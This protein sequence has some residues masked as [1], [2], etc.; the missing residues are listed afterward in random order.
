MSFDER[1]KLI[2]SR[3][4]EVF[5]SKGLEGATTRELAKAA[6]VSEGLL[7]KHFPNKEAIYMAMLDSI[8]A[9]FPDTLH[10][11]LTREPSTANLAMIVHSMVSIFLSSLMDPVKDITRI[12]LRSLAGDGEF[13]HFVLKKPHESLIPSLDRNIEAA[14]ASNDIEDSLVPHHLRS[15]FVE[16]LSFV[17]MADH[18]PATPV[19]DYGIPRKEL[20]KGVVRFLLRGI[21][22]KEEAVRRYYTEDVQSLHQDLFFR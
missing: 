13:A 17:L 20:I 4:R 7:F 18:L 16:R 10:K 5:A 6:G 21:G 15:W 2:I 12:Y 1:Q 8:E 14:I 3:V 9:D 19:V 22:L 11:I